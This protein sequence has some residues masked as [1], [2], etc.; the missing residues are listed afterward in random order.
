MGEGGEWSGK[1]VFVTGVARGQGRS[2]ALEF[3]RRG[4]D[5]GGLDLCAPIATVPYALAAP[6]DLKQTE[7]EIRSLGGRAVLEVG[8]VRD[9]A[10]VR[11]V[12]ARVLDS[13]GQIDVVITNAGVFSVGDPLTL[14]PETWRDVLD[15]NLT[16]V[17]NTV[18]A[19]LP[20]MVEGGR[21]GSIV[22]TSSIGGVQGLLQ[23]PHYVAS[24][25][26][27]IGLMRA[28]ANELAPY[29]IRV[30]AVCPTNV[31]TPMIQNPANYRTFR[32]DLEEPRSEDIVD[33][34]SA[35]HLLD[36][37]WVEPEDVTAAVVWLASDAAR[38]LTGVALPVDAGLLEKVQ[39]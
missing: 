21:G 35:M 36:V 22:M 27:V 1:V 29:R 31:N 9:P 13:F 6:A 12:V 24:K 34:A 28:L 17:W 23:C 14:S 2:H 37:P 30:N 20:A 18:Q 26:G 7:E 16:G 5:V 3:A 32:P 38:Y 39:N 33:V 8:D 15:V 19:C 25:H 11:A 10:R 4:A